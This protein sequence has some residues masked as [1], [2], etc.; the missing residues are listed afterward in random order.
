MIPSVEVV[1]HHERP[2]D[3]QSIHVL[4]ETA[5]WWPLR[6]Q[7]EIAQMLS[8]ALAVGAWQGN[9]LIGFARAVSDQHF[10][11]FIEDVL[12]HPTYRQMGLGRLL[13]A[14]LLNAL[15][16]IETITLFCHPDLVP[17]YEEHGFRVFP[18]QMV[19]HREQIIPHDRDSTI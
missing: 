18:S 16:H 8:N 6:T 14:K 4:Y 5:G 12:V 15:P 9:H 3:S 11:A 2:I 13:L 17:F 7:E 19:M 1:S 10:R